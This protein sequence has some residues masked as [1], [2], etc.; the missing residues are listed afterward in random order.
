[1][2]KKLKYTLKQF[3]MYCPLYWGANEDEFIEKWE[4]RVKR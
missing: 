3:L 4:K 2:N 1:M